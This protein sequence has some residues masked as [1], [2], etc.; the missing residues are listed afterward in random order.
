MA[1]KPEVTNQV[2]TSAQLPV[3]STP[4][5]SLRINQSKSGVRRRKLD[6]SIDLDA[7]D[8]YFNRELSHLQFNIRVLEQSLDA[9][10]PL[11]NRLFFLLIFSSNLDEFFEIRVAGLRRQVALDRE[12]SAID[13]MR[14]SEVLKEISRLCHEQVER[15]YS[16]LNEVLIPAMEEEQI[17]FI[18]REQ[19]TKEQAAWV[20]EFF[21][22]EILPVIGYFTSPPF[23][24]TLITP[25]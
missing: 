2:E 10:H 4:R 7:P 21:N 6:D 15:Q 11:L 25:A 1:I 14:P 3:A 16:L 18:R 13:G 23:F 9:S 8:L 12:K 20:K 22:N 24:I 17:R 5:T 19:W